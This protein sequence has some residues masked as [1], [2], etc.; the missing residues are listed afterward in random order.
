MDWLTDLESVVEYC[1]ELAQRRESVVE[2]LQ[3]HALGILRGSYP[4]QQ[5]QQ[6]HTNRSSAQLMVGVVNTERAARSS[7]RG[8]EKKAHP[9]QA[10]AQF[11]L[12]L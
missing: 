1:L 6:S 10:R 2:R 11:D 9:A 5:Q 8:G 12:A 3:A 7:Q 4:K